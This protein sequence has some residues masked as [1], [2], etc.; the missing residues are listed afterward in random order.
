[1]GYGHCLFL[2][3]CVTQACNSSGYARLSR[4]LN[5]QG[6]ENQPTALYPTQCHFAITG[7]ADGTHIEAATLACTGPG[8]PVAVSLSSQLARFAT[9]GSRPRHRCKAEHTQCCRA[10]SRRKS[11]QDTTK[12]SFQPGQLS[13]VQDAGAREI[14]SLDVPSG[15]VSERLQRNPAYNNR[16]RGSHPDD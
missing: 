13:N 7:A 12:I 4:P 2:C 6:F 8:A 5:M 16:Y 14:I 11:V 15:Q 1:M 10:M 3:Q 9:V